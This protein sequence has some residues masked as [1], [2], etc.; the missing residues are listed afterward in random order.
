LAPGTPR[1]L[2]SSA[3]GASVA[4]VLEQ[5]AVRASQDLGEP[6]PIV[7]LHRL[8]PANPS[9]LVEFHATLAASIVGFAVM[10]QLRANVPGV[11]LGGWLA[12]TVVLAV[13]GGPALALVVDPLINTL[14]GPFAELWYALRPS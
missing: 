11:S 10:F 5:A 9:G 8:P 2:L 13:A 1:L 4:R 7:D 3:S 14:P 12:L 6:I